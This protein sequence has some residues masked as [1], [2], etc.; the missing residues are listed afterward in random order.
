M[1]FAALAQSLFS[2]RK[3]RIGQVTGAQCASY[4]VWTGKVCVTDLFT[5]A[6]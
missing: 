4:S 1:F 2:S 5:L 6:C 3:H